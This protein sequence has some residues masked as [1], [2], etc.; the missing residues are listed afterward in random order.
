MTG[1]KPYA[2]ATKGGSVVLTETLEQ[3]AI[4]S[5]DPELEDSRG[6][7]EDEFDY[8][9]DGV[10]EPLYNPKALIK[11]LELNTYHARCISQR[12]T[13]V[14]G[15]GYLIQGVGDKPNPANKDRIQELIDNCLPIFPEVLTREAK[16]KAAVGWGVLECLRIGNLANSE[17]QRIN[18]LPSHTFRIHKDG[19]KYLQSWDGVKK[20]WFKR[21]GYGKDVDKDTGIEYPLG[22]LPP[23][24]RATE[25]IF[26]INYTPLST[27]YGSPDIVPALK[28][29]VGDISAVEYNI[30]FFR[31]YGIPEYAIFITGDFDDKPIIDP[32]TGKKTGRSTMQNMI[33]DQ[34]RSIIEKPHSTMVISIPTS[35]TATES[36]NVEVKFERLSVEVKESAFR[37]YRMENRDEIVTANKMD[38]YRAGILPIGSLGGNLGAETKKNYKESTVVPDQRLLEAYLNIHVIKNGLGITDQKIKLISINTEDETQEMNLSVLAITN[39]GMT[40]NEFIRKWGDRLGLKEVDHPAMDAHYLN[41]QPIDYQQDEAIPDQVVKVL[42]EFKEKLEG[43]K[44][45]YATKNCGES[46]KI[47]G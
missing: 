8:S 26:D 43:V 33:E 21:I 32:D 15:L 10:K 45:E 19:N 25:I 37:L 2:Y 1:G 41:G 30:Y 35:D 7:K 28:T 40:P 44:N 16:D 9:I 20:R 31:N 18:H 3:Y 22:F 42:K 14:G 4:K 6:L 47:S 5:A 34:M 46:L 36:S 27:F 29:I 17:F 38:P 24:Q 12:G 23:Q 11:L 13:D 39:G